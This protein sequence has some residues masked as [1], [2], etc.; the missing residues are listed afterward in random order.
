M[1]ALPKLSPQAY[2]EQERL[3]D[4]KHEYI[5]GEI[6]ALSGGSFAHN[7]ISANLISTFHNQPQ[8]R[9]WERG[10]TR[11]IPVFMEES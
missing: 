4:T 1:T 2:L 8:R 10:G 3:S 9:R 6:F 7:L 11:L 5:A